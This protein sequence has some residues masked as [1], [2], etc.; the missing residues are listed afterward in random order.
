MLNKI[1]LINN[2]DIQLQKYA[3][4]RPLDQDFK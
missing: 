3:I 4:K 1:S 2:V